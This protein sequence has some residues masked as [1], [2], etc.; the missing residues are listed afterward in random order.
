ML[1]FMARYANEIARERGLDITF[2]VLVPLQMVG[3]TAMV[4]RVA[5]TYAARA[6]VDLDTFLAGRYQKPA[7]SAAAYGEQVATVLADERYAS[8]L[9][10]GFDS[11]NG[12]TPLDDR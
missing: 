12:I 11:V 1:W 8:G 5:G 7:L 2:Q 9:A 3:R 6:G 10:F 4:E